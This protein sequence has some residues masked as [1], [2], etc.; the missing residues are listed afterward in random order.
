MNFLAVQRAEVVAAFSPDPT[1]RAWA[2]ENLVPW[3]V[4]IYSSY[5]EMINHPGLQAVCIATVTAAHAEEAIKAIE[6]GLHTM[7]EKPLSTTVEVSRQVVD[8]AAK[9]PDLKVLCGFSRRFDES[10]RSAFEHVKNGNIGTPCV[11]RS[12]TQDKHDPSGFFV[13][14]AKHSGGIFVDCNVHDI[15]LAFWFMGED[16]IPKS[17]TAYG[18]T[19]LEPELQKYGDVDNAMGMV[20]FWGG[21]IAMFSSS[22]MMAAGQHDETEVTGTK[23]KVAVNTNP[24]QN[25]VELHGGDG[26]R[27]ELPQTYW[28]RFREAFGREAKEFVECCLE[29]KELPFKLEGALRAVMIGTALQESLRTGKMIRF[30][31]QGQRMERARL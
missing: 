28:D 20:E 12:C 2:D 14:Y 22:R 17:I 15:D 7:C 23:G 18:I 29:N 26:I 10:Y 24:K 3:G 31:E 21:K 9:R 13:Q 19:A 16:L 25:L 1:E 4:K 27:R 11:F 30:N 8:A 5:D 6:K